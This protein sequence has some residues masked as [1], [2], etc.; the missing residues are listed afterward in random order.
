METVDE[1]VQHG[2]EDGVEDKYYLVMVWCMVRSWSHIHE[3]SSTIVQSNHSQ[4]GGTGGE[5]FEVTFSRAHV[6]DSLK[7]I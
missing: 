1:R 4:V 2:G 3:H 6:E 7:D 5:G